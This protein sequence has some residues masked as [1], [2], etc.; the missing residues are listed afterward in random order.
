M[1]AWQA[2]L[3]V[4]AWHEAGYQGGG[5]KVGVLDVAFGGLEQ[6]PAQITLPPD[7]QESRYAG[8]PDSHGTL[9]L[10][11]LLSIAPQADY[12]LY[13]LHPAGRDLEQ[14]VTWLLE[15]GV[16]VVNYSLSSLDV[17][18]DG[19]SYPAQQL[20]RL[21]DANVLVVTSVGNHGV[22]YLSE[23]YRD[24]NGDGWH[25][26]QTGDPSLWVSP[27]LTENFGEAHLRWQD[28]YTQAEIDLDLYI[29][30]ASRQALWHASTQVQAGRAADWPHE[31]SFYPTTA[32]QPLYIGIRAKT[33]GAIPPNTRF[34]LY[35][36][37]SRLEYSSPTGSLAAPADSPKLLAVGG[38]EQDESLWWRSARGPTWDGRPK[39]DLVAPAR[40]Q[41]GGGVFVG[42][43]ASSPLVAGAAILARQAFPELSE[44]E[45][46]HW[47][48]ES[49]QA[50]GH[51]HHSQEPFAYGRLWMPPPPH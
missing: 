40:L 12:Y 23:I 10:E 33:K 27:M 20:G 28:V 41:L 29:F 22:S 21:A 45:I 24:E 31:D 25:E 46:R 19:T 36:D 32:G 15:M 47:M 1:A 48:L 38:I 7:R 43:S 14:A 39:P 9:V 16:G 26:F 6:V 44:A 37:D 18:L 4:D 17:P 30:D 2:Y 3:G 51:S 34:Y 13:A 11:T 50:L 5:I 8:P 42:T 49:T 35:V